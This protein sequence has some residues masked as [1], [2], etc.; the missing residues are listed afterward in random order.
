MSG[1]EQVR[2]LVRA[3]S[4]LPEVSDNSGRVDLLR[5]LEEL[6]AAAA[7]VQLRTAVAFDAQVRA[8][9]CAAGVAVRERGRGVAGQ[10]GL[11]LRRSP[12]SA[13]RWLWHAKTLTADL[14]LV[15]DELAAG[16]TSE[17]RAVIVAREAAVLS[18]QDRTVIDTRIAPTMQACGDR[19]LERATRTLAQTLDPQAAVNRARRAECERCV[20]IRPV[21]D[22]MGRLSILA[23][24]PQ[25]V[26]A[27]AALTRAADTATA[28]PGGDHRGRGQLMADTAVERLTGQ[29]VADEVP[30]VV[31]LVM[32][33]EALLAR[34]GEPG[35]D[36]PALLNG[37]AG[38]GTFA[39][40]A[41]IAREL[42]LH[43]DAPRWLRRLFTAPGSGRLMQMDT[44]QRRFTPT[45]R[46]FLTLRDQT[47]RTPW[48]DAPIRHAD[49][50]AQHAR[51]GPTAI[52]NAQGLCAAC[53]HAHAAL[54]WHTGAAADDGTVTTTTPTGHHYDSP[55][56]RP[57]TTVTIIERLS[58]LAS[59]ELVYLQHPAA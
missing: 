59:I 41:G 32:P 49:H 19:Q 35:R 36:T 8:E 11:A 3:V 53:N 24:L 54:A 38:T 50:I 55:E 22:A 28:A 6:K 21:A 37:P 51:G 34:A 5:A 33:V 39:V 18:V 57:P 16:R 20:W 10:L 45:Q 9:E 7:A 29:T 30:V 58:P 31:N 27:Y 40:P 48:C 1:V 43:G 42:A 26:A 44:H 52:I 47:C 4:S 15:L 12:H 23:P 46:E 56:P 14:P 25:A 2:A 13:K 17:W